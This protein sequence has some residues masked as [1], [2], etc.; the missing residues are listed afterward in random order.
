MASLSSRPA[1]DIKVFL[2]TKAW[3]GVATLLSIITVAADDWVS[4]RLFVN[5]SANVKM[6]IGLWH[7]C[8]TNRSDP[9][10]ADVDVMLSKLGLDADTAFNKV[11][12]TLSI[13]ALALSIFSFAMPLTSQT[14]QKGT[15]IITTA[16][17]VFLQAICC[18]VSLLIFYI[19]WWIFFRDIASQVLPSFF[20]YIAVVYIIMYF[21]GG[22]FFTIMGCMIYRQRNVTVNLSRR[23]NTDKAYRALEDNL[24]LHQSYIPDITLR[25]D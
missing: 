25:P 2:V 3:L 11:A 23:P 8:V 13:V 5:G 4:I 1:S 19:K 9:A 24:P 16:V 22:F 14:V 6:S 12:L 7:I 17:I 18:T 20:F 10:C 21:V 15:L